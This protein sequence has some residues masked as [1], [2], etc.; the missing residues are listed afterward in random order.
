M[1]IAVAPERQSGRL[2]PVSLQEVEETGRFGVDTVADFTRR[3][4][5]SFDACT[6]CR[7]CE[8]ACP[9]F[10]TNKPLSPMRVVL[11][12]AAAGDREGSLHGDVISADT[13][14]SCT[15]CGACVEECPVLIDQLG[16]IIDMR[17]HLVGEGRVT[18][19]AQS[20]LRS[21]AAS[22]NPWGLPQ[23]DRA[24]WAEGLDVPTTEEKPDPEILWEDSGAKSRHPGISQPFSQR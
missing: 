4:L 7:R 24:L 21:I 8:T 20:A 22:G 3:Q 11:D 18:G 23:E 2:Q 13:L 9:A 15:T 16:A 17:R 10:A 12:I 5:M 1:H 6:H 14:W 19:S